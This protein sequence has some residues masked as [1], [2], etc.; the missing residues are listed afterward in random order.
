MEANIQGLLDKIYLD[1]IEKAKI[2][3]SDIISKAEAE[4]SQIIEAAELKAKKILSQSEN[5]SKIFHESTIADLIKAK[6]QTLS[7]LKNEILELISIKIIEKP[8]ESLSVEVDFLRE[9]ILIITKNWMEDGTNPDHIDIHLPSSQLIKLEAALKNDLHRE[10]QGMQIFAH[11]NIKS[12]FKIERK[13]KGYQLDF[14]MDAMESFFRNY[15]RN[16]SKEWLF[17]S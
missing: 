5:D 7:S 17:D 12:G 6:N 3:A 13:D 15:L 11:S 14:T 9:I 2:E 4:A 1:G 10:L 8:I 16:K